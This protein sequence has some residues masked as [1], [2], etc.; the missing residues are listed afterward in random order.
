MIIILSSSL[1]NPHHHHH[2]DVLD[3][4]TWVMNLTHANAFDAPHWYRLYTARRDLNLPSLHPKHW[5]RLTRRMTEHPG[6]FEK[7]RR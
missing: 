6:L 3:Y 1:H 5:D 7:F 4:E 2:Q